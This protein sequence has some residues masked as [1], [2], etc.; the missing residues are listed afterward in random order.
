MASRRVVLVAFDR[1]QGLDLVGPLEVFDAAGRVVS[2][3]R[4]GNDAYALEVVA[5]A[6]RLRTSSGLQLV[7][8]ALLSDVDGP[9]DTLV[10]PGGDGTREAF[11][12]TAFVAS[13]GRLAKRSRRVTSVCTGAFLLAQ[14]GLLDGRRV[15]THWQWCDL[16][17]EAHPTLD[18][19]PDAIFVRD[20][21][22]WTSAGVTAGMDLALALVE[23]DHGRDAALAVAR[24]LVLFVQRPGGQSQFSA[25]LSA[26]RAERDQLRDLQAW[27]HEHVADDLRVEP[28]ARRV[29]MSP[30]HFARVFRQEVGVPPATYVERARVEVARR[31]LE[32]TGLDLRSVAEASGLRTTQTLRR[33]FH[34]T[35]GV[36]PRAYRERF[37]GAPRK[38]PSRWSS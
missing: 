27:I 15:T 3:D 14:A 5:T 19:Q 33:A 28:L 26:Q 6:P 11:F 34:R 4:W 10:V 18:V 9:I 36:G 12:D 7:A 8:D 29:A 31:M 13:L 21:R 2:R 25:Q 32:Q 38:E 16:L 30:R 37:R 20:G 35:L 17:A 1:V 23:E 24:Q 22:F